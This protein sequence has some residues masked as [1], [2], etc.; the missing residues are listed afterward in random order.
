MDT[1]TLTVKVFDNSSSTSFE[2]YTNLRDAIEITT[3]SKHYQIKGPNG[4]FEL[5]FGDGRT[6]GTKPSA[7]NKIVAEYLSTSA[8][9]GN[10][11]TAAPVSQLTVGGVNYD[12]AV[13][14][15]NESAGGAGKESISSIR[16][17]APIGYLQQ[18]LVTA[19]DYKAQILARYGNYVNDVIGGW[20]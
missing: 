7:G 11:G 2:T 8:A 20:T 1:E 5:L 13:T 12:I 10:G 16:R 9:T 15:G 4:S 19:E 17:N 14:T 6:T 3:T 18:R